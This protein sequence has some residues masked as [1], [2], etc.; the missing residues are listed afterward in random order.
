MVHQASA[1]IDAQT[2]ASPLTDIVLLSSAETVALVRD[3][4]LMVFLSVAFV[5]LLIFIF[6]ALSLYRRVT[7]VLDSADEAIERLQGITELLDDLAGAAKSAGGILNFGGI[8][9]RLFGRF[10]RP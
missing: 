9:T 5:A 2:E 4:F 7:R 3:V 10:R 6:F 8:A 1:S